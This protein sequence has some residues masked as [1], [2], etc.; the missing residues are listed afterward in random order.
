MV[1]ATTM[2]YWLGALV[3]VMLSLQSAAAEPRSV[4][5][6]IADDLSRDLGYYG[7]PVIQTPNIDALAK[8]GTRFENAFATVASCSPSRSVL[9]TGQYNHTNGQYGLAHA[10]H[11]FQELTRTRGLPALLMSAGYR[12]GIIG[13][14]HVLPRSVYPWDYVDTQ[15]P[16]GARDVA[17]LADR[18]KAFMQQSKD[19]P[20]LLVIG[21][22]DPHRAAKG[23]AN[24][25]AYPSVKSISYDPAKVRVPFFLPDQPEVRADLADYYQSISR[26]DQGIGLML[27]AL[28]DSGREQETLV[29]FLSD[30]GM[31]F[32]GAKTT[33]YD[34]GVHLPLII[35]SPT[36]KQRG[37]VSNALVSWID[38]TPTVLDWTGT[39]PLAALPG[40]SLLP[41][42]EDANPAG[43]DKV[44]LS[45]TF[46]EVTMYYPVRGVRTRQYKYLWNLAHELP[47][48]P[49]SDLYNSPT[50]QGILKRGDGR[51]GER[52]FL[53][54]IKRPKEELYDLEKDPKE[55]KNL[56]S[57]PAYA[58][59][60]VELRKDVWKFQINTN[61]PWTVRQKY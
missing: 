10:E 19:Q 59:L 7:N 25:R 15:V 50:Y 29:I 20:F 53:E 48:V 39:K 38:I 8:R 60:L 21:Y 16:A 9:L 33:L 27:D 61:D 56:A 37:L 55:L 45:H 42:L 26:L 51:L 12:S 36:Q 3:F 13:K 47:F 30:N 11:N 6:L 54:Y 44:Y 24:D 22:T 40:R 5:L 52:S 31:P 2:R 35:S 46:H 1:W 57:D 18:A 43:W 58:D 17:A 32:P 23:F 4:L 28:K 14:E 34:P 41:I 49:A